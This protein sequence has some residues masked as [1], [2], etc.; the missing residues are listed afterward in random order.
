MQSKYCWQCHRAKRA[1]EALERARGDAETAAQRAASAE[2]KLQV[3]QR[4][5]QQAEERAATL[6]MQVCCDERLLP[7]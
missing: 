3:L 6:E 1:E 4:A 7:E 5:V 2:V